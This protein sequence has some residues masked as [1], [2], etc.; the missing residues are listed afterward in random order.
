MLLFLLT[1]KKFSKGEVKNLVEWFLNIFGSLRTMKFLDKMKS[2]GFS[3]ETDVGVSLGFGDFFVPSSLSDILK[4][5]ELL[6]GKLKNSFFNSR[7]SR[8]ELDLRVSDCWNQASES[9]KYEILTNFR[10]KDLLNPLYMMLLSGARGNITQIKQLVGLRGLMVDSQGKVVNVPIKNNLKKGLKSLEYFISCYGARKGVIDTALKTANSGYLTRKLI[11]VSENQFVKKPD[12]NTS[13]CQ[14]VLILKNNKKYYSKTLDILI[15]RV[16]AKNLILDNLIFSAGQDIC[17]YIAKKLMLFKKI[18]IRSPFTCKLNEGICQLCYGWNLSCGRIVELGENVGVVAAQSISEPTT[19][20]TMR[21]FHTGGIFSGTAAELIRISHSGL[22]YYNNKSGGKILQSKGSDKIFFTLKPKRMILI[23]SLRKRMVITLPRYSII[24]VRSGERVFS[25]QMVAELT[26]W[27]KVKYSISKT[28]SLIDRIKVDT[29]A[30]ISGRVK[31]IEGYLCVLQGNILNFNKISLLF[32]KRGLLKTLNSYQWMVFEKGNFIPKYKLGKETFFQ[33]I[34][35]IHLFKFLKKFNKINLKFNS[36]NIFT[37]NIVYISGNEVLFNK[38]YGVKS[39]MTN[40][41][42]P[43]GSFI[44]KNLLISNQHINSYPFHVIECEPS[45]VSVI[46]VNNT[47]SSNSEID[48]QVVTS[49]I[50]KGDKLFSS[51]SSFNKSSDIIQGLPAIESILENRGFSLSQSNKKGKKVSHSQVKLDS[52]YRKYLKVYSQKLAVRKSVYKIQKYL[53][54]KIKLVYSDQNIRVS[55]KHIELVVKQMTSKA[56]VNY[57][58]E[59]NFIKG[60]LVSLNKLEKVNSS[61]FNKVIYSPLIIGIT[62]LSLLSDSFLVGSSFQQTF[63]TICG[64]AL[65]GKC[66]WLHTL[67]GNIIVGNLVPVFTGYKNSNIKRG[68]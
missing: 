7:L 40:R 30:N 12:C 60:E 38:K 8:F 35:S 28:A 18:Y 50:V 47:K 57:E 15:G 44:W 25:K 36:Y 3:F 59:S 9:V 62:K 27:K 16:L 41:F 11:Y 42:L 29:Q 23:S 51:V 22:L 53:V 49:L 58:G 34:F 4:A 52:M 6:E 39:I 61:L 21:T 17:N 66:D 13:N 45:I 56:I 24:F 65:E 37:N 31:Y 46:N 33:E 68:V 48:K 26:N 64:A 32:S 55:D 5:S 1:N 67:K 14:L 63:Y 43:C 54:D 10:Q 20:L 19:Q 2:L